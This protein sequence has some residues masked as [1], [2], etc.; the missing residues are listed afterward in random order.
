MWPIFPYMEILATWPCV[1]KCFSL[2]IEFYNK[3]ITAERKALSFRPHR[4][5][6]F[7]SLGSALHFIADTIADFSCLIQQ[8]ITFNGSQPAL[9]SI[10]LLLRAM[11]WYA[12]RHLRNHNLF[13]AFLSDVVTVFGPAGCLSC[14]GCAAEGGQRNGPSP[15]ACP[16]PSASAAPVGG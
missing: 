12:D 4:P 6:G 11:P 8:V 13:V 7:S 15:S 9:Q 16:H 1:S 3:L 5:L 10:H 14:D 2:S